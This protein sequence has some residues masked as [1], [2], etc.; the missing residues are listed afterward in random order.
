VFVADYC[1]LS[2]LIKASMALGANNVDILV[3]KF[4]AVLT[5]EN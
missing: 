5:T 4:K 3:A 2:N 1:L